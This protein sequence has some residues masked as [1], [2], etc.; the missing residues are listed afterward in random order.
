M[1]RVVVRPAVLHVLAVQRELREGLG[2]YGLG[3]LDLGLGDGE[4]LL[5]AFLSAQPPK[6][7]AAPGTLGGRHHGMADADDGGALEDADDVVGVQYLSDEPAVRFFTHAEDVHK[8][9]GNLAVDGRK[10]DA[11]GVLL[12]GKLLVVHQE[13]RVGLGIFQDLLQAGGG[14]DDAV[15]LVVLVLKG[16]HQHGVNRLLE[17]FLEQVNDYAHRA[18][19]GAAGGGGNN[20]NGVCRINVAVVAHGSDNLAGIA[21]SLLR[22][23]GVDLAGAPAAELVSGAQKNGM[24]VRLWNVFE[25]VEVTGAQVHCENA[26]GDWVGLGTGK[27]SHPPVI[28]H[29]LSQGNEFVGDI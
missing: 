26:L 2:Y 10:V 20:H 15:R 23:V 25:T 16:Q 24:V 19:T 8:G 1:L 14:V 13:H 6:E 28:P 27:N 22:A 7:A 17:L 11:H 18:G 5:A 9:V 21:A 12:A 29:P 4:V 3:A